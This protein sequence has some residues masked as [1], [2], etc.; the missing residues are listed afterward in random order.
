M[1]CSGPAAFQGQMLLRPNAGHEIRLDP[2]RLRLYDR[3]LEL[4]TSNHARL[5]TIGGRRMVSGACF[6][7]PAYGR[8]LKADSS[9]VATVFIDEDG[10][11]WLHGIRYLRVQDERIAKE[12]IATQQ[13][14]AVARFLKETHQSRL[15]IE[16][17]GLGQFL[18]STMRRVLHEERLPASV[19]EQASKTRK[20]DRI[21]NAL[22]PLL[23]ARRL[24]IHRSAWETP[25]IEEMREWSPLA[26]GRDDG[27]DAVS[28]CIRNLNVPVQTGVMRPREWL[29][30]PS[31]QGSGRTHVARMSFDV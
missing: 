9:V 26:D 4:A 20:A 15:L 12:D 21:L 24:H 30:R 1:T 5:L 31:W 17:N 19:V 22:D 8:D 27:L 25:F 16:N 3:P 29:D 14:R 11:Y 13:C 6:W 23:A 28:G 10:E 2:D 18:P 7:D